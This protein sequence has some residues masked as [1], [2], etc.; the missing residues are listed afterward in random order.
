M[1][2]A[3]LDASFTALAGEQPGPIGL[4]IAPL[5]GGPIATYGP[6][7]TGHAWSTMKVPVLVAVLADLA[8]EGGEL[9]V[10]GRAD[11]RLAIQQSD[12]TAARALFSR[13]ERI[14]GGLGGAT[15]ALQQTLRRAG[16]D[17][18][19][20]N[21]APNDGGFTTWGQTDWSAAGEVVFYRSLAQGRLLSAADTAY[22][23]ELMR[24][25]VPGQRWG[26]GAVS[27][28]GPVAFKGGWG[29]E[30]A[31]EGRHLVRQ[32]VIVGSGEHGLV[33]SMLALPE[34]G[35]LGSGTRMLGQMAA[36]VAA[37]FQPD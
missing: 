29:P 14:H 12:N 18:V 9:D 25:V 1:T 37:S 36:W 35:A 26:A 3:D 17:A 7:Q 23:L 11:A 15:D 22:V 16:D 13:L 21:S 34:D 33:F 6:L 30:A 19:K 10:G 4:A 2:A 24:S 27:F 5:A 32:S 20:V 28:P 31:D 8:R